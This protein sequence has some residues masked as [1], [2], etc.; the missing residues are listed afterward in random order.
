MVEVPPALGQNGALD[1]GP[2]MNGLVLLVL[3]VAAGMGMGSVIY[4]WKA[5]G[6]VAEMKAAR[7][8]VP[9]AGEPRLQ[10]WLEFG[11]GLIHNRLI[12]LRLS[13]SRPWLVTHVV[14]VSDDPAENEVWGVDL[15][16]LA[17]EATGAEGMTVVVSLPPARL[18]G[19]GPISGDRGRN[20]PR[21]RPG[22]EVAD[23]DER[24]ATMVEWAL[25]RL[26]AALEKD[27]EGA[28]LEARV[29]APGWETDR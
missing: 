20:V 22:D 14:E 2:R 26:S 17:P 16:D 8:S 24:A 9:D 23:P 1:R 4:H 28:S 27:I 13:S 18:L 29:G 7:A 12:Q 3:L 10:K 5:P 21:Y 25:Q 15:T 11:Q 19:H 6:I